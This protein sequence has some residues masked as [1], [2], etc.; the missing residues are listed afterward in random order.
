[1][2]VPSRVKAKIK[3]IILSVKPPPPQ[4][5]KEPKPRL[6]KAL[7]RPEKSRS[8]RLPINLPRL[9]MTSTPPK[10]PPEKRPA[11]KSRLWGSVLSAG[12][13]ERGEAELLK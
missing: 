7:Q 11:I 2:P 8:P 13:A 1:M 10:A 9:L 5:T 4:S 6:A 3:G 12:S